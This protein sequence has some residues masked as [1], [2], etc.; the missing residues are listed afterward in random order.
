M[1]TYSKEEQNNI[2]KETA[3]LTVEKNDGISERP[4]QEIGLASAG[5]SGEE[6]TSYGVTTDILNVTNIVFWASLMI[7]DVARH[8]ALTQEKF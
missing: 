7:A 8:M 2:G 1:T 6:E 4:E 3:L 5:L